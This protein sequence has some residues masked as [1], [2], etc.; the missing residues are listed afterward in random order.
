MK[1]E[2]LKIVNDKLTHTMKLQK[3]KGITLIALVITIIVL[4]ILAGISIA[5]L[6][7]E[8]GLFFKATSAKEKAK[9]AE[10][11]EE[12]QLAIQEI[13]AEE[14]SKGNNV[15]LETLANGQLANSKDLEGIKSEL[16]IEED[17]I[18][19]DYKG[20]S[21]TIDRNLKV[22]V[23]EKTEK[24][25]PKLTYKILTEG[26]VDFGGKVQVEITAEI[27]KGIVTIE[28]PS[29]FSL[30]EKRE[31]T[32][33]KKV[34]VYSTTKNGNYEFKAGGENT[35]KATINIEI[36]NIK[37]DLIGYWPLTNDLSN[38]NGSK[39]LELSDGSIPTGFDSENGLYLIGNKY[40]KT[41]D[42]DILSDSFS[43]M[44]KV[45]PTE[46][47]DQ[48]P[49]LIGNRDDSGCWGVALSSLEHYESMLGS[50]YQSNYIINSNNEK[51]QL[52]KSDFNTIGIT[53][54][55][56]SE[57]A[58]LYINGVLQWTDK[59]GNSTYNKNLSIN[60]G[61]SPYWGKTNGY[62]KDI[63]IYNRALSAQ[64]V[65]NY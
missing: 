7:G 20:Y 3:N 60:F 23:L 55:N 34:Y 25:I 4:L 43:I 47:I 54:D 9:K 35:K 39:E 19:V 31:D 65:L 62:Y 50:S 51:T 46:L 13:Q 1:N 8:N 12:I 40:L 33:S 14:I 64:E 57:T 6:K 16:D 59:C 36:K 22:D 49:Y 38:I 58:S 27:T 21:Y 48:Y 37:S 44:M 32:D 28:F 41:K 24:E 45:K 2:E 26:E 56:A 61:G 17:K 63:K 52:S 53:Y 30:E 10:I 18:I 5:A 15:T 11:K 29:D 42:S